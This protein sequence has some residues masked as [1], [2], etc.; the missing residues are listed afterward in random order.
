MDT[1]VVEKREASVKVNH[2]RR[3]GLVPCVVC[4]GGL[5]KS[6]SLQMKQNNA[7]QLFKRYRNGSKVNLNVDGQTIPVQIKEKTRNFQSDEIMHISFQALQAEQR[8][9]SVANILLKNSDKVSDVLEKMMMEIPYSSLP[10]DMID[11]VT[12]DVD[13]FAVGT[14]IT[15]KDIPAFTSDKI[16]L[17]VDA[18]SI[19]LRLRDKARFTPKMPAENE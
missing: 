2:L 1:I 9:N 18:D 7:Q 13:G 10:A 19:V 14:V 12:I 15:V 11:T 6:I 8:V 17:Q 16:E 3:A 4:G 5:P